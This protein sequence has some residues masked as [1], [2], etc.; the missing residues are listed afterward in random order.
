MID[1]QEQF[2]RLIEVLQLLAAAYDVQRA[3]IRALGRT[4][5]DA[6]HQPLRPPNLSW[7]Q[8]APGR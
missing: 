4:V 2:S 6:L 3:A 5:L 7:L 8:Y 1:V